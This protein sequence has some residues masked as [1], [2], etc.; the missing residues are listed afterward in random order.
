MPGEKWRTDDWFVSPW[1]FNEEVCKD[2]NFAEKIQI[3]DITLRDGEQ[4]AGIVFT[5]EDK[6]RI[7]EALAEAG[8][9]RIE[10]GMPAVSPEDA[11]AVKEIATRNLGPEIYAFSRCMVDDVKRAVDSGVSGIVMEV[12]SSDHIIQY[13]YQ[14]PLEKAI[15]L[16]IESTAFAHE[17]GLKVV[18][19]PIDFT[20][21]GI[22]W[23]LDLITRVANEGHMDALALVDTFGAT[24]LHAMR[25]F[26]RK[27]RSRIDKPL[28]AHFHMD[29]GMGIANTVMALAEGAEAFHS[30]VLGIGERAGNTPMEETVMALLTMYGIDLGIRYDKLTSLAHLVEELSG[31]KVPA[32]K[33]V[34]GSNLFKV[35][36]GIIASWLKNC[37]DQYQTELFPFR[38]Q[39]I[40]QSR[41]EIVIGKGSGIDSVKMWLHHMEIEATEEQSMDVLMA[42]KHF[43]LETKRLMTEQEFRE[44]AMSITG[45]N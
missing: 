17:Q 23:V 9:H 8:V 39:F 5:K 33:P 28:E 36:S 13:A 38:P 2:L 7:A 31:Q 40:G 45:A 18:F 15:D 20:R 3:H 35:E 21:S 11:A 1:N 10:A 43:S 22:D 37:G 27:V 30:T 42:V 25:Y 26:V 32:N 16:S 12:P 6:I 19:F 29:F 34:V 24:S 4:Q 44:L 14:W 41:P